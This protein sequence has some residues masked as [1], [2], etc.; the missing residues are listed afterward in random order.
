VGRGGERPPSLSASPV[1]PHEGIS[2]YR[3]SSLCEGDNFE[4]RMQD[5]TITT[6][7]SHG[8]MGSVGS[9]PTGCHFGL[10]TGV[11]T[12]QSRSIYSYSRILDHG[13]A[14]W[15]VGS[16]V[17][18]FLPPPIDES[19]VSRGCSQLKEREAPSTSLIRLQSLRC[20]ERKF[21]HRP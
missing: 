16:N 14:W 2:E 6:E 4:G 10:G 11:H 20:E 5:G 18:G 17:L 3:C 15:I 1:W 19:M 7:S 8:R 21:S 12:L 13:R 9:T